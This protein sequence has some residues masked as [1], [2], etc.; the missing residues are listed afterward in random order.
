MKVIPAIDLKNGKCVR[1]LKGDF[2][3]VTEYSDDP[4]AVARTFEDFATTDLHIVDL[5]DACEISIT[6]SRSH[7]G[8]RRFTSRKI[9]GRSTPGAPP[10][11]SASSAAR[12]RASRSAR[13][14]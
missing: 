4:V 6:A 7:Q 11:A 3:K 5:D 9:L 10:W 1:L 14:P 12:D 13:L 2:D 8:S